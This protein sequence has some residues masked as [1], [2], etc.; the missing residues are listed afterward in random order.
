[1]LSV[2][3]FPSAVPLGKATFFRTVT[4]RALVGAGRTAAC[5]PGV[6]PGSS[7]VSRTAASVAVIVLGS[8]VGSVG[9]GGVGGGGGRRRGGGG[10]G[11]M[12]AGPSREGRGRRGRERAVMGPGLSR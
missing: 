5:A 2:W 1:M 6:R 11:G 7:R 10:G 3:T 8:G 4:R 12:G 9:G